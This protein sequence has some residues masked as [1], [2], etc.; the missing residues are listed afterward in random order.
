M[1]RVTDDS[2]LTAWHVLGPEMRV[3]RNGKGLGLREAA[4]QLGMSQSTLSLAERGGPVIGA[5][6]INLIARFYGLTDEG[7]E[8]WLSLAGC[9]PG[10]IVRALLASPEQWPFIRRVL[11][12]DGYAMTVADAI[13]WQRRAQVAEAA[14]VR[15]AEKVSK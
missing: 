12:G 14:A 4:R 1:R 6:T 9:L 8:R 11:A 3:A 15:L 13:D 10:D 2:E 7:R 5:E